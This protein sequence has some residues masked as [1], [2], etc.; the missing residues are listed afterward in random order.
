MFSIAQKRLIADQVQH[1]L[2]STQHHE[3]PKGEIQFWLHVDGIAAW[4]W[5]DIRNNGAVT[6]PTI[7][8]WNEFQAV[9]PVVSP[10]ICQ[11]IL[12]SMNAVYSTRAKAAMVLRIVAESLSSIDNPEIQLKIIADQLEGLK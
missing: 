1:I 3:L 4:S 2:R 5:A 8:P 11:R 7:N 9:K 10:P 12:D 6:N